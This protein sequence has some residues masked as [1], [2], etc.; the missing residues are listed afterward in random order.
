MLTKIGGLEHIV[1]IGHLAVDR[2]PAP[3]S[4]RGYSRGV[5]IR[6]WQDFMTGSIASKIPFHRGNF[7][8]TMWIVFSSGTTGKPKA[9]YGPAGGIILMRLVTFKV[10]IDSNASI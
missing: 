5:A 8:D 1:V 6:S 2:K 7:N 9:I 10:G 4:L 3:E